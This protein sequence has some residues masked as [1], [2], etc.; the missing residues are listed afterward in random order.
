LNRPKNAEHSV[1]P[2][3]QEHEPPMHE[4]PV[5]QRFPHVPQFPL[6]VCRS[7][8]AKPH[9]V[10]PESALHPLTHVPLLQDW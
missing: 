6:L 3:G 5:G 10:S 8:Q 4:L 9:R 2:D 7:T 1:V